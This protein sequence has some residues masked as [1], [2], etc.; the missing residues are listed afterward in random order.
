MNKLLKGTETYVYAFAT[1]SEK[2]ITKKDFASTEKFLAFIKM[3]TGKHELHIQTN[4]KFSSIYKIQPNTIFKF[5]I[6]GDL[7]KIEQQHIYSI[8]KKMVGKG[9]IIYLNDTKV[10]KNNIDKYS[11]IEIL[12]PYPTICCNVDPPPMFKLS[13]NNPM[14]VLPLIKENFSKKFKQANL[15]VP[16]LYCDTITHVNDY[17]ILN[18]ILCKPDLRLV[19]ASTYIDNIYVKSIKSY[20]VISHIKY[21]L[22]H[23]RNEHVHKIKNITKCDVYV[24]DKETKVDN[25]MWVTKSFYE[26]IV[27]AK[28]LFNDNSI[29]YI[30]KRLNKESLFTMH[31]KLNLLLSDLNNQ[32]A[33]SE[34]CVFRHGIVSYV[35]GLREFNDCDYSS[36]GIDLKLPTLTTNGIQV[37]NANILEDGWWTD[38][39]TYVH[40]LSF[41]IDNYHAHITDP[42]AYGYYMGIKIETLNGHLTKRALV[43]RPSRVAEIIYFNFMT[44]SK[45]PIYKPPS[46]Y[47]EYPNLNNYD[48]DP[49]LIFKVNRDP[50]IKYE[51]YPY[52][53]KWIEKLYMVIKH[54][55]HLDI[56]MDT[57]QEFIKDIPVL[58]PVL[59]KTVTAGKYEPPFKPIMGGV[60]NISDALSKVIDAINLDTLEIPSSLNQR[61]FIDYIMVKYQVYRAYSDN[62]KV[63]FFKIVDCLE[64]IFTSLLSKYNISIEE[65][66]DMAESSSKVLS[67]ISLHYD[68]FKN[69]LPPLSIQLFESGWQYPGFCPKVP[70]ERLHKL[71]D[72]PFQHLPLLGYSIEV[73]TISNGI[74]FPSFE[75]ELEDSSTNRA[76]SNLENLRKYDKYLYEESTRLF[77]LAEQIHGV[78][79]LNT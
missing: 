72:F 57:L 48:V 34:C 47:I 74:P 25:T 27:V 78:K 21:L 8:V 28:L 35:L 36:L 30:E 69:K 22:S 23:I 24:V 41:G 10:D 67:Y 46:M 9:C 62:V 50:S 16:E 70:I 71:L 29:Q 45:Y 26:T 68:E 76:K 58:D 60:Y 59:F 66:K 42:R 5:T 73:G 7:P 18:Y 15:T 40:Q 2:Y 52:K 49:W 79:Y 32:L 39:Q 56:D 55:F 3:H 19:I 61:E 37:D 63:L 64:T 51:P 6:N 53:S 11:P 12:Y 44:D 54:R 14:D 13:S 31:D 65:H 38:A 33:D 1:S 17:V 4:S 75:P 20:K 43:N 77:Q